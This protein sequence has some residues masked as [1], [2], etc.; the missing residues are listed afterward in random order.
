[1]THDT[2]DQALLTRAARGDDAAFRDLF[3]A[4]AR[5]V[6]WVA[7][8]LLGDAADAED[9]VQETFV[10]AWRRLREIEL[11]GPSALPWLATICRKTAANRIRSRRTERAHLAGAADDREPD[12]VDVADQVIAADLA[13]RIAREVDGLGETDRRIFALCVTAGYAYAAA[14]AEL[15]ITQGAV[16]NRLSRIRTRLRAA[17][18][19]ES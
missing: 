17:T 18:R 11:Q 12:T 13:E 10:V 16:R 14:A 4:Y 3:R 2:G 7:H 1:M 6:Y 8:G 5:P 9:V 19:E 15:G